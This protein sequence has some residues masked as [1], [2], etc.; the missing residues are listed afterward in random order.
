M[1][2]LTAEQFEQLPDFIKSEYTEVEGAY[3]S[4]AL[5]TV[6]KTANDLDA[7][8]KSTQTEY[9]QTK[10]QLDSF[11]V[12][13]EKQL[14]EQYEQALADAKASNKHDVVLKLEREKLEDERKILMSERESMHELQ[15]NN[16][17]D[18]KKNIADRLTDKA[19]PEGKFAFNLLIQ[20][21][22]S[23]DPKTQ[24]KTFLNADGSASSI[25]NEAEFMKTLEND[26][27]FKPLLKATVTTQN[28]GL[29]NGS[30]G[31]RATSNQGKT[32]QQ[33]L[34]PQYNK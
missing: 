33:I 3:K 14:K 1:A 9:S 8:L 17:A 6:K 31:G 18:K 12:L 7:K 30:N 34:Y 16:A 4:I 13:K 27:V 11:E 21:R 22:I 25:T 10:E 28:G 2:D 29:A 23:I 15:V 5:M 26:E 20:S 19:T 32:A 24:E